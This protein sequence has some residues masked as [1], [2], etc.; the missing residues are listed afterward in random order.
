MMRNEK[1][2]GGPKQEPVPRVAFATPKDNCVPVAA[3]AARYAVLDD[4]TEHKNA[5]R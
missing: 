3:S 1:N 4:E 2:I 5:T